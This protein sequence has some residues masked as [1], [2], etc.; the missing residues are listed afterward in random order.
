[1]LMPSVFSYVVRYDSGFAP[2]P[3]YDYCTLATCKPRIRRTAKVGD[4]LVGSGSGDRAVK[5]AGRLVY[6]MQVTETLTF[7]QFDADE[8]FCRKKP[9]RRGSRKQSCGDNIYYRH[10]EIGVWGQR[11][12]FHSL[13]DGTMNVRHVARDTGV[14]R[15]LVSDRFVY[16]GGEGPM[17]PPE[18]RSSDGRPLTKVGIGESRFDDPTIVADLA[19]WIRNLGVE[20]YQ[21]R[22]YEWVSSG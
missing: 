3:F 10:P 5:R 13:P 7:E 21:G 8:R 12:S 4:W 2:N 17:I 1:M 18:L 16:F 11:D 20:G 22:P 6:A 14:N 9:Y 19:A 15:V